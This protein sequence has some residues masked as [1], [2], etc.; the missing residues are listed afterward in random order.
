MIR[1]TL[2]LLLVLF[3]AFPLAA[4]E[5]RGGIHAGY[6]YTDVDIGHFAYTSNQWLAGGEL[7][8][9]RARTALAMS[10]ERYDDNRNS[11]STIVL[12]NDI[13]RTFGR[14]WLG[15]GVS[16]VWP[17]HGSD[18]TPNVNG[19]VVFPLRRD[20]QVY[21]TARAYRWDIRR[22]AQ[23]SRN[24]GISVGIRTPNLLGRR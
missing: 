6:V 4:A 17:G 23:T 24:F 10:L 19:G 18:V 15:A 11:H 22:G 20:A 14:Y 5:F 8:A 9:A 12:H 21:V 2:S 16:M 7:Y 1:S 13:R 3:F